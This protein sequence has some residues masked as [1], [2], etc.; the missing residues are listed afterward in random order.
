[1]APTALEIMG[2]AKPD[3]MTG[4]S[5]CL[6][7]YNEISGKK[8][9]LVVL[10]GWGLGKSDETNPIFLAKTPVW[11]R[12]I[13][14]YPSTKLEASGKAVG[15]LDWKA[16]NSEAGHQTIGAGRT[17]LQDDARIEMAIKDRSFFKNPV[18]VPVLDK[19]AASNRALNL[20][21]LL[22]EKSSHDSISYPMALLRLAK[23]RRLKRVFIHAIFDGRSTKVRSAG[24]FLEQRQNEMNTLGIGQIASGIGRGYA[25][26]R[27]GDYRKTKQAY[28][29]LVFGIG[30]KVSPID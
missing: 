14:N 20:I 9:L 30:K 12:L 8:V 22:S 16:G 18:F 10:D 7:R 11:D 29:A 5:L 2:L 26:D 3:L 13:T 6:N 23:K 27:D 4:N 17:V 19:A 25:L 1:M 15:L 21:T 24:G 28:D